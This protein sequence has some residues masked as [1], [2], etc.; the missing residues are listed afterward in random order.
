MEA[1]RQPG[2][3]RA[4]KGTS[5][6][7]GGGGLCLVTVTHQQVQPASQLQPCTVSYCH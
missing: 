2:G 1:D 3:C 4:R 7:R 6:R 5:A